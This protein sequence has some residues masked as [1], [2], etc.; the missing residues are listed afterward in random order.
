MA[1]GD[2]GVCRTVTVP[3]PEEQGGGG[4]EPGDGGPGNGE[5]GDGEPTLPGSPMELVNKALKFAQENPLPTAGVVGAGVL[6]VGL[7]GDE[8]SQTRYLPYQPRA[9][10]KDRTGDQR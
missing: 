10:E 8:Q 6:L 7:G 1:N 4:E 9:S 3:G 2:N 5:P